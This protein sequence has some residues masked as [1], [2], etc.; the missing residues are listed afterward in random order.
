MVRGDSQIGRDPGRAKSLMKRVLYPAALRVFDAALYVGQRSRQYYEHYGVPKD[1]LFFSPHCVDTRWFAE[2]SGDEAGAALRRRHG[3]A[4]SEKAVL[5]AGK[6][7]PFKRP[8]DLLEAA[9]RLNASGRPSTV[10]VAGSGPLEAALRED[11]AQ[12]GVKLVLLGFQNQ[13][14]MPACYAAADCLVLPSDPH[15][16]WGLV[17]NEA[18]ACGRPVVVSDAVGCAPDL[19]ADGTAGRSFPMGDCGRLAE[20]IASLYDHPPSPAAI[21]ARIDAYSIE[22]ACDGIEAA[23]ARICAR[24]RE[25]YG[26]SSKPASSKC[27]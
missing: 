16:T 4:S 9:S 17:V 20:A 2:R 15:E 6:L 1:R 11:A 8:L 10:M 13:T 25:R 19:A 22:A 5:F 3:L 26:K 23:L 21:K 12:K 18:L 24:R 14:E 27:P 7:L